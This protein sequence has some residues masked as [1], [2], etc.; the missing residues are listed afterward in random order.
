MTVTVN[1]KEYTLPQAANFLKDNRRPLRQE[2]F[3][4]VGE[5]RLDDSQKLDTPF[6]SLL[7]LRHQHRKRAVMGKRVYDR[8]ALGGR[9]IIHNKNDTV[10]PK[11]TNPYNNKQ[12]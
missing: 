6:D 3:E 2:A 8:Q 5:R 7:D 11:N 10:R 12:K 1:D 4:Q 9:R